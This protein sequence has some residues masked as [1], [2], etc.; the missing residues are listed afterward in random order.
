MDEYM[1]S[2]KASRRDFIKKGGLLTLGAASAF[3]PGSLKAN[4]ENEIPKEKDNDTLVIDAHVHL[5]FDDSG[6]INRFPFNTGVDDF[7]DYLKTCGIDKFVAY[8]E[9]EEN[10]VVETNKKMIKFWQ[11]NPDWVIPAIKVNP[12]NSKEACTEMEKAREQGIVIVGELLTYGRSYDYEHEG[13]RAIFKKANELKMILAV[14]HRQSEEKQFEH[15]FDEYPDAL[16]LCCHLRDGADQ[17]KEK[18]AMVAKYKNAYV[19]VSGFG[20][21]RLG[22]WEYFAKTIG[23]EKMFFGSDYPINDPAIYLARL[24]TMRVPDSDKKKILSGNL[25]RVL[26]ERNAK[27]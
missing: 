11:E 12:L 23:V 27:V 7:H 8:P 15:Y 13:F 22:I 20:V 26:K 5:P 9:G 1:E 2:K 6:V 14:H 4:P 18:A 17:V 10:E 21:D 25:L 16:F 3:V 24:K 19:D